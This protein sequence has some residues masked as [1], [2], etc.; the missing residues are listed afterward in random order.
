MNKPDSALAEQLRQEHKEAEVRKTNFPTEIIELPSK[1]L[2]YPEDHPLSNGKIE[3]KY[4]TAREEDILTSSNLIKQG[5]VL[6]TLLQSLIVTNVSYNEILNG[7]KN[8]IMIAGRVLGYGKD[9]QASVTCPEC[10]QKTETVIDLTEIT[11]KE[12]NEDVITKGINEFEYTLPSSKRV[13]RFKA[14]T[15]GD[16]KR[17]T[18]DIK[19][20]K[21][22][23][24]KLNK[25]SGVDPTL[26]TRLTNII[27]AVDGD[28]ENKT[29]KDFV[30][31]ELFAIDSRSLRKYIS[32]VSPD[33][34][35][36]FHFECEECGHANDET[37]VPMGT[38]FFWP[39]T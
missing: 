14:L 15:H 36:T 30:N 8:A 17:I 2:L 22:S 33:I 32:S 31:Q 16:E 37:T 4:M 5:V 24:K 18:A 13:I 27:T 11:N 39:R 26:T 34:D 28:T 3:M 7:D 12:F 1:G 10:G 20:A 23:S 35:L 29:I 25:N 6:D 21:K 9:Y 38:G 19:A